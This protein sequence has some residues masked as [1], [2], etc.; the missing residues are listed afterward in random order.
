M[1][2]KL[3]R[4]REMISEANR[5]S[6]TMRQRFSQYII[7]M[8]GFILALILFLMNVFGF[9]DPVSAGVNKTL[10]SA[11]QE[12]I[13]RTEHNAE[14]LAAYADSFSTELSEK[15]EMILDKEELSFEDLKDNQQALMKL[16]SAAYPIIYD[17][18]RVAPCS[19]IF[20]FL[21]TTVNST[22]PVESRS[23]I[24]L[25][26]KNIY[27]ENTIYNE[28]TMARGFSEIARLNDISLHNNWDLE[29]DLGLF[30]Q[31]DE[32]MDHDV[33]P[34]DYP[35]IVTD[36]YS[37]K[38]KWENFRMLLTPLLDRQGQVIGVCG[39]EVSN[40]YLA[41]MNQVDRQ[42]Q[43]EII[44]GLF[45]K[46]GDYYEGQ[47]SFN[48]F[49][50]NSVET[51]LFSMEKDGKFVKIE[52]QNS[53]YIAKTE[54]INM[55]ESEF[56]IAAMLPMEYYD[57]I[58]HQGVVRVTLVLVIFMICVLI[59]SFFISSRYLSPIL[60]G[61]EKIRSNDNEMENTGILEI[62]DLFGYLAERNDV[63]QSEIRD[64]KQQRSTAEKQA[65]EARSNYEK[66]KSRYETVQ[67][68][69]DRLAY[70]RNKE[71]DPDDYEAFVQ[72]IQQL[73]PTEK[74]I[75]EYYL[76]GHTVKEILEIAEIKESTLRYHNR[77]IYSKLGVNSLKQLLRYAALMKW[78][79]E[80]RNDGKSE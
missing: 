40:S 77:N 28:I 42:E 36:A 66:T 45:K 18:M 74:E 53:H 60:K 7:L 48:P 3:I 14:V 76:Q 57:D 54:P 29:N 5:H 58:V 51:T 16:H 79:N 2:E 43:K 19:G 71:I 22:L 44:Y 47:V 26:Y 13:S 65:E 73:T 50:Q 39:Y 41:L 62:D 31:V 10:T 24:Y 4:I 9:I 32:M 25:K 17:H 72:G 20:Y 33:Y 59:G 78:Q 15:I 80:N 61:L 30:P 23:G 8:I 35:Y 69:I 64:L 34:G 37:F 11:L 67:S 49:R 75:F 63:Q 56:V 70:E 46:R 38:S 1:K 68:E 27:S 55:G 6:E 12:S 21:N 52:D